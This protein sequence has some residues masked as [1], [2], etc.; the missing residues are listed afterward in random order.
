[1][2]RKMLT[3]NV[4]DI[5]GCFKVLSLPIIKGEHSFVKVQCTQCG[6]EQELALSEIKLRPKKHCQFCRGL[7]H[8][9]YPIPKKG[10][11]FN[12]WQVIG[13]TK[14][15]KG[16]VYIKCKCLICG[17]EQFIRKD[18]LL[19]KKKKCEQCKYRAKSIASENKIKVKNRKQNR[20]FITIFNHVCAV[21]GMRSIPVTITPEYI[22]QIYNKQNKRCAITGD[23]LPDIRKASIDRIDSSKPYEVGNIQIVTKQANISKHVMT[24]EQ[25]YEFC[26]KVINYA[27]QKP[28]T[29]LTK[30]EGSE[31]NS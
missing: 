30:C 26:R 19:F 8:Q 10:E 27:N 4:G 14:K 22:E 21:A 3:C 15:E 17:H 13:E 25:L 2:G 12:N 18:Q 23:P 5:F 7:G 6:S 11:V 31:T 16:F 1:M 9:L 24:M 28:S 29:P 20:P